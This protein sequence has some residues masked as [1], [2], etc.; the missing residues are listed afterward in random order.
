MCRLISSR[1]AGRMVA[2]GPQ[3]ARRAVEPAAKHG[4][5]A[6]D[7]AYVAVARHHDWTLVSTDI[8]DLVCK[9]LAVAPDTADYP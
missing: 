6:Y 4:L 2:V 3:L 5:T 9:G 1:C 7:A 8:A